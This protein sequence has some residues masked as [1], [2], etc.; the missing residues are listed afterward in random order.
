[1]GNKQRSGRMCQPVI[2]ENLL[3]RFAGN[4]IQRGERLIQQQ[5]RRPDSKC[6]GDRHPL[7]LPA[8]QGERVT[9]GKLGN[10]H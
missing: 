10:P 2:Q 8:A 7:L 5:D 4:G 3:E 6:P 9:A 1:M